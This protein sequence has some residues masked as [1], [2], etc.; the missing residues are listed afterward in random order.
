MYVLVKTFILFFFFCEVFV[1]AVSHSITEYL[2]KLLPTLH[3]GFRFRESK[4]LK[5]ILPTYLKRLNGSLEHLGFALYVLCSSGNG[6]RRRRRRGKR[7]RFII[8]ELLA[9]VAGQSR[10]CD[11]CHPHPHPPP[12]RSQQEAFSDR[13]FPSISFTK[14][15]VKRSTYRPTTYTGR[16]STRLRLL[17]SLQS[18]EE[19]HVSILI[20]ITT[21]RLLL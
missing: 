9:A 5:L 10:S 21:D 8:H 11:R 7:S 16:S 6:R 4:E 2:N 20:H 1:S 17:A 12:L 15:S 18:S 13:A 19:K 3:Y 14:T